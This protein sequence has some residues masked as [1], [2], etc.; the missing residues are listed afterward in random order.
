[1]RMRV[2]TRVP[3]VMLCFAHRECSGIAQQISIYLQL[4]QVP[5]PLEHE[6]DERGDRQTKP[7]PSLLKQELIRKFS[8][9]KKPL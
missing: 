2:R 9:K 4:Q 6:A 1:M 7:A 8:S 5:A 3:M